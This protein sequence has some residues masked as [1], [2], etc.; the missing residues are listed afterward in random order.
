M[1]D[2]LATLNE[3]VW[4]KGLI[5]LCLGVGIFFS[6]RSRL[7]QVRQIPAMLGQLKKGESSDSGVSSFQA[8]AMSLASTVSIPL[9]LTWWKF[10]RVS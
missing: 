4:S 9:T 3:Y 10:T 5:Y 1:S 8:L 2:L 6:I 7:V